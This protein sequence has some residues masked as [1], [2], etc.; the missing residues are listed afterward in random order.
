MG[1]IP[2]TQNFDSSGCS[3]N[4]KTSVPKHNFDK[5][6]N[7]DLNISEFTLDNVPRLNKKAEKLSNSIIYEI[8]YI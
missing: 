1:S 6:K 4:Y 5:A 2:N 8:I 7:N 3:L